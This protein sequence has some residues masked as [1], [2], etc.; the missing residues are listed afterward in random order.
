MRTLV[1]IRKVFRLAKPRST[2][3]RRLLISR[4]TTFFG[5][6]SRLPPL[7]LNSVTTADCVAVVQTDE[8]QVGHRTQ[9]K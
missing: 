5:E 8:S 1:R 4:F 7:A 2:V 6:A 3:V 9:L